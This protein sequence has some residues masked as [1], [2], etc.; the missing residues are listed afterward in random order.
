[1]SKGQRKSDLVAALRRVGFLIEEFDGDELPVPVT[2]RVAVSPVAGDEGLTDAE[3]VTFV[4][5][6]A[7][8]VA[9]T[10]A[11]DATGR[12]SRFGWYG[13]EVS[14]DDASWTF[15]VS[16]YV[17]RPDPVSELAAEVERLREQVAEL[18]ARETPP[19]E[20]TGGCERRTWCTA[21]T[22]CLRC[23]GE[24]TAAELAGPGRVDVV[25]GESPEQLVD[26]VTAEFP[27]AFLH[28]P[29]VADVLDPPHPD[30]PHDEHDRQ[31]RQDIGQENRE[32]AR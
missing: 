31:T 3:Q 13:F 22:P 2:V 20:S 24:L 23:A 9:T 16:A 12:S 28:G 27:V 10:A 26:D 17:R 5:R 29:T 4:N 19:A 21:Q 18:S 1:M 30:V 6:F 14:P 32:V 7:D 8:A 15:E 25:L 11:F